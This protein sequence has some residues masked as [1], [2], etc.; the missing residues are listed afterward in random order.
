MPWSLRK[1]MICPKCEYQNA[2]GTECPRCGI[3]FSRYRS[4]GKGAALS[5]ESATPP[6]RLSPLRRFYRIFRWLALAG[7]IL[8]VYLLLRTSPPPQIEATRE[9]AKRAEMKI[10]EFRTS[11][12][13]GAPQVLAMNEAELNGWLQTN[14]AMQK[15][16]NEIAAPSDAPQSTAD[17]LAD[18]ETLE[19]IQSSVRDVKI[20]L[21]EDSLCV[22]AQFALHG[23]D[24]SLELEGT[25][26][27]RNGYLK[28]EP[29]RGKIGSLP[30]MAGALK[31]A[32]DRLFD[33]PQNREKF[34]LPPEIEDI[35]VEQAQLVI[36]SR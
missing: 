36:I 28:L 27:V 31:S 10:A 5:K 9:S 12:G 34:R 35:R 19:Q 22:Y 23:M 18:E 20:D 32:T 15:R 11:L 2:E 14:L 8:V 1:A 21:M 30:L 17:T 16:A 29:I 33:S 4:E 7:L 25:P 3:V 24:L 26:V 13:R 6:P